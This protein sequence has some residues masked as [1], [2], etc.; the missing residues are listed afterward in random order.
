VLHDH[1]SELIP[2]TAGEIRRL[3]ASL[4]QPAHSG[5]H[6]QQWSRW[7]RRHQAHARAAHY[8]RRRHLSLRL[9]QL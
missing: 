9:Q 1:H 4:T 6:Y 8:K 2:L 3:L 7:R 5:E